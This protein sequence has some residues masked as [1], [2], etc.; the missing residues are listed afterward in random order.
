MF[1]CQ[2]C[3]KVIGKREKPVMVVTKTRVKEY[4]K[5]DKDGNVSP[6]KPSARKKRYGNIATGLEIEQEIKC[7]K[8]CAKDAI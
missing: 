8:E 4:Y 5:I 3:G 7:C 1:V 6:V 2:T